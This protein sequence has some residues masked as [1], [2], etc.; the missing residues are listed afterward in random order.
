VKLNINT[1]RG[2]KSLEYEKEVTTFFERANDGLQWIDTPKGM[3][4]AVDGVWVRYGELKSVAEIKCRDM[5]EDTFFGRYKAEWLL[6]VDKLEKGRLAAK[7]LGVPFFGYLALI[8]SGIV[9]YKSLYDGEGLNA[10]IPMA[11]AWQMTYRGSKNVESYG[12]IP[13]SS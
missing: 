9:L 2:Q 12:L 11:D 5:S 6:S 7:L 1:P 8:Q 3:P 4:A 13:S 10:F